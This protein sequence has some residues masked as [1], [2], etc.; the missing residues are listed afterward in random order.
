MQGS[1]QYRVRRD[2]TG[3]RSHPPCPGRPND[4]PRVLPLGGAT[5]LAAGGVAA[6]LASQLPGQWARLSGVPYQPDAVVALAVLA[7]GVV[8]ALWYAAT[9]VAACAGA[10]L[11]R[12]LGVARWGAPLVRRLAA[13]TAVTMLSVGPAAASTPDDVAW[14]AA[15]VTVAVVATQ[16][17]APPPAAHV[18]APGESL[19]RI[20]AADLPDADDAAVA[21]RVHAYVAANPRVA[22]HP[23]L[24]HPGDVLLVPEVTR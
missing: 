17:S 21:T 20:A 15:E 16:P 22:G 7:A 8:A 3:S 2:L 13:G 24:I 6:L 23:D 1:S 19:W 10:V 18:V 14:G 5:A 9:G 11:R 4:R 12:D